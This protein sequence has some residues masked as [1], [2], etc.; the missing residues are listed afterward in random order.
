MSTWF[1][2]YRPSSE[3]IDEEVAQLCLGPK[4]AMFKKREESSQQLK[5]LYV[6]GHINGMSISRMLVDNGVAVNLMPYLVFKKL[7][8][9]DGELMTTN[10][11]LNVIF[12]MVSSMSKNPRMNLSLSRTS[13]DGK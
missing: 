12:S 10:L 6:R 8:K 5:S 2:R 11:T 13:R 9:E 4:E 3:G 7:E 1:S